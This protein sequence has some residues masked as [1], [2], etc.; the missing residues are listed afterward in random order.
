VRVANISRRRK[1]SPTWARLVSGGWLLSDLRCQGRT[2]EAEMVNHPTFSDRRTFLRG[3]AAAGVIVPATSA[4]GQGLDP[5]T[6][7][8]IYESTP[9]PVPAA[10]SSAPERNLS[11]FRAR[12]WSEFYPTI[13]KGVI[14]AD[15]T[16]RAVHL[17][18]GRRK[19]PG[20]S[21]PAR[22]R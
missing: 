1:L 5:Y 8:P 17:L 11:S 19:R 6:G 22:S 15:V 7:Q 3:L 2:R 21:F 13:G 14:L 20:L 16:S 12:H 4:F 9:A 18:V 10:T